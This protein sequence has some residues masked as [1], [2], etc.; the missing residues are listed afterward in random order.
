VAVVV[1]PVVVLVDVDVSMVPVVDGGIVIVGV[2][3]VVDSVVGGV[4][5]LVVVPRTGRAPTVIFEAFFV[6]KRLCLSN[7][8]A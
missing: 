2:E 7:H 5:T 3:T 1:V 8:F 4:V 6:C